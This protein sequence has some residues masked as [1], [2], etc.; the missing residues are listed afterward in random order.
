MK[1]NLRT[2]LLSGLAAT[3]V[4]GL[5]GSATA[6]PQPQD[7]PGRVLWHLGN[8]AV[9]IE[10][11]RGDGHALEAWAYGGHASTAPTAERIDLS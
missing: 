4:L 9:H 1:G 5:T 10:D 7:R 3:V 6:A 11:M 8:A 2:A